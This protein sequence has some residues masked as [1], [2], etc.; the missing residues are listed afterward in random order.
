MLFRSLSD[1]AEIERIMKVGAVKA[2][3]VASDTLRKVYDAIGFVR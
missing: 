1:R 3:E 2:S